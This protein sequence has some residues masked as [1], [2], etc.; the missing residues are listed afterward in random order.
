MDETSDNKTLTYDF[1]FKRNIW[2]ERSTLVHSRAE[3][4]H[5]L[6]YLLKVFLLGGF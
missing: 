2:Q 4:P 1:Y 5:P 3:L 6:K